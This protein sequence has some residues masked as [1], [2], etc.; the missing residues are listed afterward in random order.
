MSFVPSFLRY[1]VVGLLVVSPCFAVCFMMF[2]D[3]DIEPIRPPSVRNPVD[4]NKAA[5]EL[6]EERRKKEEKVK[7]NKPR[8]KHEKIEFISYK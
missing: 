2:V 8:E 7:V 3:D 6:L 4:K 1:L 5:A